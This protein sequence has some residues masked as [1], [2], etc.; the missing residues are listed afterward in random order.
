MKSLDVEVLVR[1]HFQDEVEA[2]KMGVARHDASGHRAVTGTVAA[3]V[4]RRSRLKGL[5]T[6]AA[7]V[8]LPLLMWLGEPTLDPLASVIDRRWSDGGRAQMERV[9][10][11]VDGLIEMPNSFQEESK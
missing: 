4:G 5:A 7:L 1:A 10:L 8:A 6:A 9:V 3:D 11:A 2:A